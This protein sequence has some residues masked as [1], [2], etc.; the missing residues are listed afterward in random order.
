MLR[1]AAGRMLPL[2]LLALSACATSTTRG[3]IVLNKSLPPPNGARIA[4][5][6]GNAAY[7]D[8]RLRN[9]ERD[10][11]AIASALEDANFEV[12]TLINSDQKT[13]KR[14]IRDFGIK[15]R[16]R[17]GVALFYFSGHAMQLENKNYLLPIGADIRAA[18]DIDAEA[19][20]VDDVTARLSESR[21]NIVILDACRDDPF[22]KGWGARDGLAGVEAPAGTLISFATSP[23]RTA[24]DGDGEHGLFTGAL[25]VY[26]RQP[27]L[28]IEEV[29]KRT[30]TQV[31]MKSGGRQ[32]PWESSSLEGDFYF[33]GA[34]LTVTDVPEQ[35]RT[36][37]DQLREQRVQLPDTDPDAADLDLRIAARL[38]H[39]AELAAEVSPNSPALQEALRRLDS[40][41]RLHLQH[42]RYPDALLGSAIAYRLLGT[43]EN[44][45]PLLQALLDEFPKYPRIN[46]A[47]LEMGIADLYGGR[48]HDA[49]RIL[50]K[51]LDAG[52]P[53]QR[54]VAA[55]NM[56]LARQAFE[57]FDM[58]LVMAKEAITLARDPL[59]SPGI[60]NRVLLEARRIGI[61]LLTTRF[62]GTAEVSRFIA[63]AY[64]ADRC[65]VQECAPYIER[66]AG[67]RAE[68]GDY[69]EASALL[70]LCLSLWPNDVRIVDFGTKLLWIAIGEAG[71][72]RL[73]A[74]LRL[75]DLMSRA[76]KIV[77]D[78]RDTSWRT[79]S[80]EMGRQVVVQVHNE[81][82]L[83]DP[84][85]A[86]RLADEYARVFGGEPAPV[87]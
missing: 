19:V 25:L 54:A 22:A 43:S 12:T 16:A 44:G 3:G 56:S 75:L 59:T 38:I 4:L 30:R 34:P 29:L 63:F 67:A 72:R 14:A 15:I 50:Q 27:G 57:N 41:R 58:S 68:M 36:S 60:G 73:D 40:V 37:L 5:V 9:P 78:E 18:S 74:A 28:K 83:E 77:A 24:S 23:G 20:S 39:A 2:W 8:K 52:T 6:V 17:P 32:V 86:N 64:G 51:A 13:L 84:M 87:R 66:V 42:E 76:R 79:Q 35:S 48:P 46:E 65:P 45:A 55:L 1:S 62:Q 69:R 10:A 26:M 82:S 61:A 33:F 21:V 81:L 70:E 47:R 31:R 7:D 71:P 85:Q 49:V 80:I 11:A 53:T